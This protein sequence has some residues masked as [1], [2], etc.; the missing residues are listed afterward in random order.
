[1]ADH[2]DDTTDDNVIDIR[3]AKKRAKFKANASRYPQWGYMMSE[4]G[5]PRPILANAIIALRNAPEWRATL[6]FDEF[7][8]KIVARRPLPWAPDNSPPRQWEDVHDI[9]TADWLQHQDITVSTRVAAEAVLAVAR[10]DTFHPVK[11]Y[12][13]ALVWDG[14]DR[15]SSWLADHLGAAR[16]AY[17]DA[18]GACWLVSA[19]A[20]IYRPGCKVDSCLIL[21]GEQGTRKSSAFR[22]LGAPWFTDDLADLGS[23]DAAMQLLGAWIIELSELDS[24]QRAE[25]SKVKAFMSRETDRFRPPYGEHVVEQP[26]QSVFCGT[27]NHNDYLRDE[28]GGRRF[29]PVAIRNANVDSLAAARNQLWAQAR[30][31]FLAG[32]SWWFEGET[33]LEQAKD[34]QFDAFQADPWQEHINRHVTSRKQTSVAD[35][36]R[37]ELD[38]KAGDWNQTDMNRIARC[39]RVVGWKRHQIREGETR[40]WVYRAADWCFGYDTS[41]SDVTSS[42]I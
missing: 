41:R 8:R 39:L 5:C 12:L 29:W 2:G 6:S 16:S 37:M 22:V 26:R 35:I 23:K 31:M 14:T 17:T 1:M 20:R 24:M 28:T 42:D 18:A 4:S 7:A 33:A 9:Y 27:V 30:D 36:L 19:V 21:E 32:E 40:R 10:D 25:L 3:D 11:D 34:A 15:A 13:A 38:R